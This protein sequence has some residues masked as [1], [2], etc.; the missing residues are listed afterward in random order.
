MSINGDQSVTE[1]YYYNNSFTFPLKVRDSYLLGDVDNSGTVDVMD[2]TEIQRYLAAYGV[3]DE[4][5]VQ[6]GAVTGPVLDIM[7]ATMIQRYL[8]DYSVYQPI[9]EKMLYD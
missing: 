2:A 6:R 5:T 7:G 1:A 9:G 4:K 8:A 3:A